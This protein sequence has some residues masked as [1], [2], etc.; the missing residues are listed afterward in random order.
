MP[1]FTLD[2]DGDPTYPTD[3]PSNDPVPTPTPTPD[4]PT[5]T[6]SATSNPQ[7]PTP[8]PS[9]TCPGGPSM[10]PEPTSKPSS[11]SSSSSSSSTTSVVPLCTG[12]NSFS[13]LMVAIDGNE[14]YVPT[15][16]DPVGLV[17]NDKEQTEF[18]IGSSQVIIGEITFE[19][20]AAPL[21]SPTD[22]SA[23]GYEVVFFPRALPK[24]ALAP[25]G[26]EGQAY[27]MQVA[28]G[29][30]E[31]ATEMTQH[32]GQF[33][34]PIYDFLVRADAPS[35]DDADRLLGSESE[36]LDGVLSSATQLSTFFSDGRQDD[37]EGF[38]NEVSLLDS[39]NDDDDDDVSVDDGNDDGDDDNDGPD[40]GSDPPPGDSCPEPATSGDGPDAE[41]PDADSDGP[42]SR[43]Q[44]ASEYIDGAFAGFPGIKNLCQRAPWTTERLLNVARSLSL[45]D[46]NSTDNSALIS[47][48]QRYRNDWMNNQ[49][50]GAEGLKS[51]GGV[52]VSGAAGF[53]IVSRIDM[54]TTIDLF[55]IRSWW[56]ET[57]ETVIT[58]QGGWY[59]NSTADWLDGGG[60]YR[61]GGE[62]YNVGFGYLAEM[63]TAQGFP[64]IWA[65]ENATTT[66]AWTWLQR[67]AE[68]LERWQAL[69]ISEWADIG[70]GDAGKTNAAYARSF[71]ETSSF[72]SK[73]IFERDKHYFQVPPAMRHQRLISARS[74]SIE[75]L[76]K[77]GFGYYD[78][79]G[80]KPLVIIIDTGFNYQAPGNLEE[81]GISRAAS[82]TD[83]SYVVPNR[84]TLPGIDPA[85]AWPEAPTDAFFELP[86]QAGSYI[87]HGTQ[88]AMMAVGRT[89]GLAPFA[90][91]FIIKVA[92]AYKDAT[93]TLMNGRVEPTALNDAFE[94][95]HRVVG[96][97]SRQR[98]AVV[99]LS[100]QLSPM[101]DIEAAT[102][103]RVFRF[104]MDKLDR[105]GVVFVQ[106]AGNSGR[107][108]S[109]PKWMSDQFPQKF[110]T[111]DNSMITVGGTDD[112]GRYWAKTTPE[113]PPGAA[114]PG[115]I[116][117]WAQ[118][119]DV[120][121]KNAMGRET[122]FSGTSFAAP[123]VAG[124]AAYALMQWPG[125]FPNTGKEHT[126]A[127]KKK[128]VEMS[129]RR[130]PMAQQYSPDDKPVWARPTEI[131]VAYNNYWG[132]QGNC[133][134]SISSRGTGELSFL[135]V[136]GRQT[137]T[138]D[139]DGYM[140]PYAPLNPNSSPTPT[141]F[142]TSVSSSNIVSVSSGQ[143]I[144]TNPVSAN[145]SSVTTI[146]T[147]N[148]VSSMSSLNLSSSGFTQFTAV[149]GSV[150]LTSSSITS[151]GTNTT[152]TSVTQQSSTSA[153]PTTPF[154]TSES[155]SLLS[156]DFLTLTLPS[157]SAHSGPFTTTFT[158]VEPVGT[159][160]F[161][162]I[163][164]SE[165]LS[166]PTSTKPTSSSA[167][168]QSTSTS[169]SSTE[170][171]S[172][173]SS[174][175]F[176]STAPKPKPTEY[177]KGEGCGNDDC[178]S[179][180]GDDWHLDC[181]ESDTEWS[182]ACVWQSGCDNQVTGHCLD[183]CGKYKIN[184]CHTDVDRIAYPY[185]KCECT[186][187]HCRDPRGCRTGTTCPSGKEATCHINGVGGG[188]SG[189]CECG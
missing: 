78:S 84:I 166:T 35:A 17:L 109:N 142:M 110:G 38:L 54:S 160:I 11:S 13:R 125:L 170:P 32:V 124:L 121:V 171:T 179:C 185:G 167:S 106:A 172:T 159:S 41:G 119:K 150:S 82:L 136:F 67:N 12:L 19:V 147:S 81:I 189:Y 61:N 146:A 99:N 103:Q 39:P 62:E 47:K 93:G 71:S 86:A 164:L 153:W 180:A 143:S 57:Y 73:S 83:W 37:W 28:K 104:H 127:V 7:S 161:T 15:T 50:Q 21:P 4:N 184:T 174:T 10:S 114:F 51:G 88:V 120:T 5:V 168:L 138:P 132:P 101:P 44:T 8:T 40:E 16:G 65:L 157:D 126:L 113:G 118:A 108:S 137:I 87:G 158:L 129:Y 140:C 131:N 79:K 75:P 95:V 42:E 123:Q 181:T 162:T 25:T 20:P 102:W 151:T 22:V 91:V 105:N 64:L 30:I 26:A 14:Y 135:Q 1:S 70:V 98:R 60:G 63:S 72:A 188:L 97:R 45:L 187:L 155:G 176:T 80:T 43:N 66:I 48:L 49:P 177:H 149:S 130:I 175:T 173:A 53:H 76:D 85:K 141:T 24:P 96:R 133:D 139:D 77:Q 92:N 111:R 183:D 128:L 117:I 90:D 36:M 182:C 56:V 152:V 58:S 112:H 89:Y 52:I 144:S 122:Q 134:A 178:S 9:R 163:Y 34:G 2:P 23:G 18:S 29:Y 145:A 55:E 69:N 27:A 33:L 186:E 59:V 94:N 156:Y 107:G 68:D 169:I 116:T 115:S 154:L 165:P 31:F 46:R 100:L 3:V 6:P 74:T 148:I